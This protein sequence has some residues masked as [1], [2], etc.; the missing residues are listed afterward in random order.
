MN[1]VPNEG[2]P[3]VVEVVRTYLEIRDARQF[4]PAAALPPTARIVKREA[5]SPAEYRRLY[6]SVGGPWHWRDRL[7]WDD[8]ALAIAES[9]L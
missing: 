8:A 1:R 9:W 3:M 7:A 2:A 6:A 4:R 5:C